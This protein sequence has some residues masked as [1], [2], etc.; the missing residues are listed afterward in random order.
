MDEFVEWYKR[1]GKKILLTILGAFGAYLFAKYLLGYAAPFIIAWIIASG[2]QFFVRW[3]NEKLKMQR[4]IATALSMVT[5]LSAISWGL[6]AIGRK[7]YT[8][9][10]YLYQSIP[11][12]RDEI[13]ATFNNISDKTKHIFSTLPFSSADTLEKTIDE[14]FTSVAG[15]LGSFVS[16]GSINVVSK[17]PNI[18]FLIVIMLLSIFF[19]TRDYVKIQKFMAAQIPL[20]MKEKS[21]ILK[22][23]LVSALGGYART[24]LILMS[25]TISICFIGFLILGVKSATL[26]AITI[27]VVDALPIFGSGLFLIPWALYNLI[28][29]EFS[30]ALGL[31]AIYALI[32]VVRQTVEPR[33]LSSQ[34]GIYTLVTL[35]AM[36]VGFK[37]IGVI[38]LIIG[39]IVA[40]I[41]QTLQKVDLL[42]SFKEPE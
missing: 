14:V 40:I 27:G 6:S 2:L 11:F 5:V 32:V 21:K 26:L 18:F 41:I 35:M 19:M 15:F 34:I 4:G 28:L 9:A 23:D 42:P 22:G 33:I 20:G 3:L 1:S 17:L 29:G 10:N 8:Q 24:Q 30:M 12:Y 38:G 16:K 36:Y 31:G 37:T 39:P 25:I 7:I 13:F